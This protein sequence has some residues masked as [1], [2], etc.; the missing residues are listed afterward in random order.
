ML[1]WLFENKKKNYGNVY[2]YESALNHMHAN[3]TNELEK[4]EFYSFKVR[5]KFLTLGI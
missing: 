4:V 1:G 5:P 2:F 3:C